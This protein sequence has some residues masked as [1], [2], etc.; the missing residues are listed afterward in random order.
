MEQLHRLGSV[1]AVESEVLSCVVGQRKERKRFILST[2]WIRIMTFPQ[3]LIQHNTATIK[4][5]LSVY[6]LVSMHHEKKNVSECIEIM[7]KLFFLVYYDR[8]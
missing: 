1:L 6:S 2:N 5:Y 4:K 7:I 8:S 3:N